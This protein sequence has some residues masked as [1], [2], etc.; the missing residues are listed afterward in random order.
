M[1]PRPIGI[2]SL[3]PFDADSSTLIVEILPGELFGTH[4]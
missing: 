2:I 4:S 3:L 1:S